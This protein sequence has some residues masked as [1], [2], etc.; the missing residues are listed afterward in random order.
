[1]LLFFKE[2]S[3]MI[4]NV[5]SW[6]IAKNLKVR[7]IILACG[8]CIQYNICCIFTYIHSAALQKMRKK[9]VENFPPH[10]KLMAEKNTEPGT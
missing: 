3:G 1:M 9:I 6:N 5:Q 4:N 2:H 10:Q 7:F 8:V